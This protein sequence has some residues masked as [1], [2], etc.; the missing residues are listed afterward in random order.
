MGTTGSLE[1]ALQIAT[2]KEVV[3]LSEQNFVDCDTTDSGCNGGLMDYAFAFAKKHAICTEESYPYKAK[4]GSC[5]SS[6]CTIGLPKGSVTGFTDVT[7]DDMQ[8]MM[9]AVQQQPVSVAIEA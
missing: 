5:E 7:P 2:Q 8:A 6:S 9:S 4:A 1:G 3:S